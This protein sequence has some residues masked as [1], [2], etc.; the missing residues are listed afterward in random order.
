MQT[1]LVKEDKTYYTAKTKPDIRT[2]GVINYLSIIGKGK[3][4]GEAFTN[5][6]EALFPVAYGVRKIYKLQDMIFGVPKLEGLWW[7]DSDKPALEV[8]RSEWRW[9][10][11]IRMPDFVEKEDVEQAK[12]EVLKKK[13]IQLIRQIQFETMNEG[14]CVQIMHIGPYS[15]E[16]GT[17]DKMKIFMES[18]GLSETGLH[19]EIYISDPRKTPPEKMKTILRQAVR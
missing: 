14:K 10:L 1:D 18:N 5:A 11:L 17:I 2:F 9:K 8:P 4:A 16:P 15:T 3:P 6:V 12:N 13:G 7:V 19:H